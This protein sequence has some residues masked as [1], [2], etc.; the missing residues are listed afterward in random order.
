M[1]DYKYNYS[2]IF[3]EVS[4]DAREIILKSF[5]NFDWEMGLDV[6]TETVAVL[7]Y[8]F[9]DRKTAKAISEWSEEEAGTKSKGNFDNHVEQFSGMLSDDKTNRLK[10]LAELDYLK[11]LF[12]E[13]QD[14]PTDLTQIMDGISSKKHKKDEFMAAFIIMCESNKPFKGVEHAED[15]GESLENM[16]VGNGNFFYDVW[17][18]LKDS[19]KKGGLFSKE[20]D[21]SVNQILFVNE[22]TKEIY[23]HE[24]G[25][26]EAMGGNY[27]FCE[28]TDDDEKTFSGSTK[29]Y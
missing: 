13:P 1:S 17:I 12:G 9:T 26:H 16:L 19:N 5:S 25:H 11:G 18:S 10:A 6:N 8:G 28:N 3:T 15:D 20:I 23:R 22:G 7:D 21:N 27:N 4:D 14:Q 2:F 29:G 24:M